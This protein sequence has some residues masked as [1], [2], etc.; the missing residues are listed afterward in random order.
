VASHRPVVETTKSVLMP[1][2]RYI[3]A[4]A[5]GGQVLLACFQE[6]RHFSGAT[7]RRFARIATASPFVAAFGVGLAGEPAPGVR[8]AALADDDPLRGEWNVIV[9]GPHRAVALVARDLGDTG[10]EPER[11]FSFAVTHNRDLV[12][13]AARS[14]LR[15]IT[16][17]RAATLESLIPA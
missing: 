16:P 14:L 5:D 10:P 3:E 4:L 9:I 11:R 13:A 17:L 1:I 8:G 15:W 7:A 2:S 12:V 6:G